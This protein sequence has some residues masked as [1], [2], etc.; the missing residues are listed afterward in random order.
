MLVV[1]HE[2]LGNQRFERPACSREN[3]ERLAADIIVKADI[4][5]KKDI[6]WKEKCPPINWSY[7][8]VA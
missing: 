3:V 6:H 5:I 7:Q 4:S 1:I 8:P 2:Q